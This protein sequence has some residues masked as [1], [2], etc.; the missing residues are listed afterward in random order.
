ML[1]A[2]LSAVAYSS[3]AA[4]LNGS[5]KQTAVD[6]PM[7]VIEMF[8]Q[9]YTPPPT[10]GAC[11]PYDESCRSINTCDFALNPDLYAPSADNAYQLILWLQSIAGLEGYLEVELAS[12]R[13][14]ENVWREQLDNLVRRAVEVAIT[15]V[16]AKRSPRDEVFEMAQ[17][18]LKEKRELL[19]ALEKYRKSTNVKLR[20][21]TIH[22]DY[23][24]GDYIGFVEVRPRPSD[25]TVKLILE[26]YFK[27]C[28]AQK[29]DPYSAKCDMWFI[30][31]KEVPAGTYRYLASWRDNVDECNKVELNS[32]DASRTGK[33]TPFIIKQTKQACVR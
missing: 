8:K 20:R 22:T 31:D 2:T 5:L 25:G 26:H 4:Q 17:E 13:Y 30:A 33:I 14:P 9:N 12:D 23:C 32:N 7:A 21:Y 27:L 1:G 15:R 28:E 6:N 24:G 19:G 29:I 10:K 11:N 3:A 18:I 16:K